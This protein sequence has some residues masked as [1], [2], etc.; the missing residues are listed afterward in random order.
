[1]GNIEL[2][3]LQLGKP[4]QIYEACRVILEKG[5]RHKRGFAIAPGCELS[6]PT[7]PYNVWM[8]AKA[9]NDFGYFN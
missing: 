6:P 2:A 5:K 1:M 3:L 8:V 4:E 9:I 7:P